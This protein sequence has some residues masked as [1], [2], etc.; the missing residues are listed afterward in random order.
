MTFIFS[1][2]LYS[3][4]GPDGFYCRFYLSCWDIIYSDCCANFIELASAQ[5][6]CRI[7]Q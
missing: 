6:Y 5:I 2:D 3:A 4:P 7:D 1:I